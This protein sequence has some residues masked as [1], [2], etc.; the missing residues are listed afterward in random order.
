MKVNAG[1]L[2]FL[3]F[4]FVFSPSIIANP[5]PSE[6]VLQVDEIEIKFFINR[7]CTVGTIDYNSTPVLCDV[8]SAQGTVLLIDS[9]WCGSGHGNE[10]VLDVKL[11]VDDQLTSIEG[12]QIYQGQSASLHRRTCLG[13]AYILNSILEI[14]D[15]S[16]RE[17]ITLQG[18]CCEK[19]CE[20]FYGVLGTRSNTL[21]NYIALSSNGS[22]SYSGTSDENDNSFIV[23]EPAIA[24]AQYDPIKQKGILTMITHGN[25]Q[26]L[27]CFIWDR[28]LDNK[29]YARFNACEGPC[30]RINYFEISQKLLFFESE[31][32]YWQQHA[33]ELFYEN[34]CPV[35]PSMDT[36]GD[37]K[38]DFADFA[39]FANQWLSSGLQAQSAYLE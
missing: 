26:D 37:C 36:N 30:S 1:T 22:V 10:E 25:E 4:S 2:C 24:V 32:Q 28:T 7:C 19:V 14:N 31:M 23:L 8:G 6:F 39:E 35:P 16:I 21:I 27:S 38:I 5:G 33:Q 17:N 12:G 18:I 34:Y 3:F 9:N 11:I 29:F 15:N 13:E 20:T